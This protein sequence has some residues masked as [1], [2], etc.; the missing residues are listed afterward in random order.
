MNKAIK[1][2]FTEK[3]LKFIWETIGS[4]CHVL[5]DKGTEK[6]TLTKSIMNKIIE[7]AW[8]NNYI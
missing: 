2:Y 8:E 1:N 7:I 6:M 3:E 4:N 5:F